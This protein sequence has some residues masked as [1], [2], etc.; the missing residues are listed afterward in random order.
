MDA[1]LQNRDGDTALSIA[2]ENNAIYIAT[3]LLKG[4]ASADPNIKKR[5]SQTPLMRAVMKGFDIIVNLLIQYNVN[6]DL[7][8]R[9]GA[10]ALY[11]ACEKM[12]QTLPLPF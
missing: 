6:V 4:G 9:N 1:D 3:A 2:C 11:I 8:N 10:T 5:N 7:Q 12:L